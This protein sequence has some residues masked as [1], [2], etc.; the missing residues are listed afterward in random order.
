MLLYHPHQA[1]R[2]REILNRWT[3]RVATEFK[4]P[5]MFSIDG[6]KRS[7][8]LY[9]GEKLRFGSVF[10]QPFSG[11]ERADCVCNPL[12]IQREHPTVYLMD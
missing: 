3:K 2:A 1:I 6:P 10:Q 8:S 9:L 12:Y 11:P 4:P 5:L 7:F